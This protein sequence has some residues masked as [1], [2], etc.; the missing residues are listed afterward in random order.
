MDSISKKEKVGSKIDSLWEENSV[1]NKKTKYESKKL[2]IKLET[3]G[4]EKR[5]I[6][7]KME[8]GSP[9]VNSNNYTLI[10][11]IL[12]EFFNNNSNFD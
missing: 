1:Y 6:M 3:N 7:L 11:E 10:S 2:I 4:T 8:S 5:K 12:K 9:N